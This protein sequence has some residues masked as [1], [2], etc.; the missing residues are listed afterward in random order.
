MQKNGNTDTPVREYLYSAEEA[1]YSAEEAVYSAEEAVYFAEEAVYSAEEAVYFAEEPVYFAKEP[2]YEILELRYENQNENQKASPHREGSF[3]LSRRFSFWFSFSFPPPSPLPHG[4]G[5]GWVLRI[6][7]RLIAP[8]TVVAAVAAAA[9]KVH[10]LGA[11]Q[12]DLAVL[13]AL[14]HRGVAQL[15]VLR[16]AG[17]SG[18]AGGAAVHAHAL[19]VAIGG[20]VGAVG[21]AGSLAYAEMLHIVGGHRG[22]GG[23]ED[24]QVVELHGRAL[25]HQVTHAVGALRQH[26]QDDV[27][28]VGRAVA[29]DVLGQ[30]LDVDGVVVV[31]AGIDFAEVLVPL[32]LVF[33]QIEFKHNF[34]VGFSEYYE[35]GVLSR[36]SRYAGVFRYR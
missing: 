18:L 36:Q 34:C 24:A 4:R 27:V 1:H 3:M 13:D 19:H 22:D 25:Q 20:V 6:H 26:A 10:A 16:H 15:G 30:T 5:W 32:N 23:G 29:L 35:E 28:G 17:L 21:S 9:D 33:V 8:A 11:G 14:G 31:G 12:F 7:H 2:P